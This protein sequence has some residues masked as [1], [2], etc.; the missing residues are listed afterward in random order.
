MRDI[1]AKLLF[2]CST[3][4]KATNF[5]LASL[6]L[7]IAPS[8][9]LQSCGAF[10]NRFEDKVVN[11]Q[12]HVRVVVTGVVVSFLSHLAGNTAC[13]AQA[14]GDGVSQLTGGRSALLP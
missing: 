11:V 2:D 8:G 13:E 6:I 10:N 12:L 4:S 14:P 7:S 9:K 3:F 5:C 1:A